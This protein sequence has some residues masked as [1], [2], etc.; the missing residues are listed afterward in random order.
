M[1]LSDLDSERILKYYYDSKDFIGINDVRDYFHLTDDHIRDIVNDLENSGFIYT[2]IGYPEGT[3]SPYAPKGFGPG[4]LY[5]ITKKGI[6]YI[7]KQGQFKKSGSNTYNRAITNSPNVQVMAGSPN[8]QQNTSDNINNNL[9]QYL[10]KLE[11][12]NTQIDEFQKELSQIQ[13]NITQTILQRDKNVIE[14]FLSSKTFNFLPPELKVNL[15]LDKLLDYFRT[16]FN[17]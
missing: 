5:Q 6:D 13:Q 15:T 11:D 14:K 9:D 12:L 2:S 7:E 17:A 1:V 4:K 8:Q 10:S 16:L 3:M